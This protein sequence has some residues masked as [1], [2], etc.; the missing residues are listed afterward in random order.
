MYA[1]IHTTKDK[2]KEGK[3]KRQDGPK[4]GRKKEERTKIRKKGK[5]TC[6]NEGKD[7]QK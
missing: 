3:V 5:W 1:F 7:G 4:E 6:R 2:R